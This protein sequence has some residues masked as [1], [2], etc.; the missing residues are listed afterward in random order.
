MLLICCEKV[1]KDK[2]I[3]SNTNKYLLV[4][5]GIKKL[6]NRIKII[7]EYMKSNES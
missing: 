2:I 6:I 1:L 4:L 3:D 7:L 5:N